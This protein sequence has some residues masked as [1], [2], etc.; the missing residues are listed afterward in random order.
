MELTM[1]TFLD[2]CA[3]VK[4]SG[5]PRAPIVTTLSGCSVAKGL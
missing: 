3:S 1:A 2:F 5:M 4:N